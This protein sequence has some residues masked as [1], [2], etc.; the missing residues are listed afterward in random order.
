M[1][2]GFGAVLAVLLVVGV[3]A[4]RS[5]ICRCQYFVSN[6]S[7]FSASGWLFFNRSGGW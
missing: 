7:I 3:V 4:Y 1:Q 2:I 6:I 5:V